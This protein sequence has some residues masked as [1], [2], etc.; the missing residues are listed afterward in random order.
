MIVMTKFLISLF[1]KIYNRYKK[2]HHLN[3]LGKSLINIKKSFPHKKDEKKKEDNQVTCYECEKSCHYST[4][5]P[6]L[7]KR[8]NKKVL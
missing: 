4:T 8:Y 1:V 3:H 6:S 2:K 7:S 5:C